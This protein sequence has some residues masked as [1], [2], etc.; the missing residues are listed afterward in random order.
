[1]FLMETAATPGLTMLGTIHRDPEARGLVDAWMTRTRPDAITLEF[2]QYGHLYRKMQGDGLRTKVEALVGE[3]ESDGEPVDGTA[4]DRVMAY[5]AQPY[6]FL[7]ARDYAAGH[8]IP[9]YLIDM[10]LFSWLNLQQ[11]D[12][13]FEREN[14]RRILRKGAVAE[15]GEKGLARLFFE[16]GLRT[17]PY[18]GEMSIRDRHMSGRLA[19]LRRERHD[20]SVLHICGWRHLCDPDNV[21]T[22]LKPRKAFVYDR[23]V[24]L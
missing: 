10:D 11:A 6:E 1:M 4:L 19:A 7:A 8:G 20:L 5:V 12:E 15:N 23:T 21:Y 14:L 17:F 3:L 16:H 9:L 2:S 13:L 18:T 24:R 22:E